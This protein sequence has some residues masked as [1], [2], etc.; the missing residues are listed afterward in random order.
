MPLPTPGD[1]LTRS[2]S[3]CD[4]LRVSAQM[5]SS[6]PMTSSP[7]RRCA[8]S[9]FPRVWSLWKC[10]NLVKS[11]VE[12]SV[13]GLGEHPLYLPVVMGG[14]H[15]GQRHFLAG[16]NLQQLKDKSC[17]AV[18]HPSHTDGALGSELSSPGRPR[19]QGSKG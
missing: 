15:R 13:L 8:S 10:R 12:E 2:S 17:S 14:Q 9:A 5:R 1:M 3:P 19:T 16:C 7:G 11:G 18:G 4:S 6:A